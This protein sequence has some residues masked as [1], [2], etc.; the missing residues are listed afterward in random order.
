MTQILA[1]PSMR[2]R[3]T[4][5]SITLLDTNRRV[6]L[7]TADIGTGGLD[8][9]RRRHPHR[10]V[11]FGI[12][13][14]LL[15]SAAAG[16]A[17]EG[18]RPIAH[19]YAPFLVERPYEQIKLDLG[20]QGVGAILV[21][22]GA[23][24]DASAEGRTHQAPEDVAVL[25]ALPG[26]EIHVPGHAD[27]LEALLRR[28][29]NG[30]GNVYV[31]MSSQSNDAPHGIDGISGIRRGSAGAPT[32]VAIGPMLDP[33]IEATDGLDVSVAYTAT[34]KPFDG[35]GLRTLISGTDVIVVEPVLEGT[36]A[37]PIS[38]A[39]SD[40]AH[41]L[42]AIGVGETELHRYGSPEDH[43]GAH[44]LDPAGLRHRISAFVDSAGDAT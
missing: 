8:E 26:W 11:N 25:A 18:F 38:A 4:D 10:V 27:E 23:S 43:A 9:A 29:A 17:L 33:V 7:L 32:I 14:Q 15:I 13:E 5:T 41:R 44:G 1:A 30:T 34:A 6:V 12:R 16:F 40:R 28:A 19:S 3:F 2:E 21:S 22:T 36:S 24:F 20:H 35:D 31:R 37:R 39:L 42:L